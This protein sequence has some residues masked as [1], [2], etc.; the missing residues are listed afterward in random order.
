VNAKESVKTFIVGILIG[1]AFVLPGVSGAV[2]AVVFG[3][4]ERMV[5]VLS[6]L[7][8]NL[9][10]EFRFV[11]I[12]AL[13]LIAGMV[14]FSSLFNRIPEEYESV[15]LL[16]FLGLIMGQIPEVYKLA[17]KDG[18][19]P[20]AKYA[21]WCAA[22]IAVMVL[23]LFLGSGSETAVSG[24]SAA[25]ILTALA[26]GLIMGATGLVPGMS[27][28]TLLTALGL[29][30][31]FTEI[32]GNFDI[33]LLAPLGIGA[34]LGAI[35]VSRIMMKLLKVRY[36]ELYYAILGLTAGSIIV[37]LFEVDQNVNLLFGIAAFAAGLA[38]SL[39]FSRLGR[40]VNADDSA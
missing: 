31:V 13:G 8:R 10:S 2:I 26:A 12:L 23:M 24:H 35:A 22:G 21:G 7:K 37:T 20:K 32:L 18:E 40:L 36:Y 17:R 28:P 33:V 14:I 27:G 5:Y 1:I 11:M 4:Y 34:I 25:D 29:Y 3:I 30:A 39:S 15:V 6:D 38:V 19:P 16:A 9:R